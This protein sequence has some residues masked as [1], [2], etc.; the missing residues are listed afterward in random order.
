MLVQSPL[1]AHISGC[2]AFPNHTILKEAIILCKAF[3]TTGTSNLSPL[4]GFQEYAAVTARGFSYRNRSFTNHCGILATIFAG[5]VLLPNFLN[6]MASPS[7]WST[8]YIP[9]TGL[10]TIASL[11]SLQSRTSF[12]QPDVFGSPFRICNLRCSQ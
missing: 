3:F 4:C 9:C 8:S 5:T 1:Q 6:S 12:K 2:R 10:I 11:I 7:F